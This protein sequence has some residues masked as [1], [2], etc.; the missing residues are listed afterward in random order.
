MQNNS[1]KIGKFGKM[2]GRV[3]FFALS[4]EIEKMLQQ[5]HSAKYV[6]DYFSEQAKFTQS[7][8]TF[9]RYIHKHKKLTHTDK[10][11]I[12]E[13]NITIPAKIKNITTNIENTKQ[14]NN[15]TKKLPSLY[16]KYEWEEMKDV[17]GNVRLIAQKSFSDYIEKIVNEDGTEKIIPLPIHK[18]NDDFR[19]YV[20]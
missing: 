1:Q 14:T 16:D 2:T 18:Y 9:L 11:Q 17:D 5:G 8:Q 19:N 15:I 3:E 20:C 6:F 4:A 7:Y 12:K 13:Q 10:N